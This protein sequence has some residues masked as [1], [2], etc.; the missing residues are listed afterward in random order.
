MK[1]ILAATLISIL[2]VATLSG[3]NKQMFDPVYSFD[4]AIISL[5]NGEIVEGKID[6]WTDYEDGDQIQVKIDGV[7]YLVH[8][9]D[10]VLIKEK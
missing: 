5:P 10:V 2:L 1:K 8:S 4:K 3:C 9:S 6:N 7:V